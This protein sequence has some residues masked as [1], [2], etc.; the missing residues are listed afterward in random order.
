MKGG[1]LLYAC[2]GNIQSE[3]NENESKR[4]ETGKGEGIYSFLS[5]GRKLP[6][7]KV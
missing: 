6:T 4:G 3:L 2:F 5:I 7:I 1:R